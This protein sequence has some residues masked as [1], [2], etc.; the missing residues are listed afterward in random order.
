MRIS[1]WS[2]KI[3]FYDFEKNKKTNG[4]IIKFKN[5][6]SLIALIAMIMIGCSKDPKTE[7]IVSFTQHP[8]GGYGVDSVSA[9]FTGKL[10]FTAGKKFIFFSEGD[11]K[12]ITATVEWWWVNYYHE[13]QKKVET[14]TQIFNSENYSTRSTV[15]KARPGNVLLNYYWVKIH[16]TDDEGSHSTESVKA[17]CSYGS[18]Q[19]HFIVPFTEQ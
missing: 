1:F 7:L 19:K 4:G 10:D 11:P 2:V 8:S 15:Y 13:N 9:Q 18:L 3:Y 12:P 5:T 14:E 16:W 17:Y 6:L